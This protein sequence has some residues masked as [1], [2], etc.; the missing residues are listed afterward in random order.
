M[1][2]YYHED[3]DAVAMCSQCG[4]GLCKECAEKRTVILCDDCAK[5]AQLNREAKIF[6]ERR[7]AQWDAIRSVLFSFGALIVG[8]FMAKIICSWLTSNSY[9]H[10]SDVAI[11]S[12]YLLSYIPFAWLTVGQF[13]KRSGC[14]TFLA[15]VLITP[16][17]GSLF[18]LIYIGITAHNIRVTITKP[19]L[20]IILEV[21]F[22][23]L[24]ILLSLALWGYFVMS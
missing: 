10:Y 18:Y 5:K 12:M 6:E 9:I 23:A 7:I 16:W 15:C 22:I 19:S 20:G 14:L 2:C 21:L 24:H 17:F 11:E 3:R 8:Y 4:R 13:I 1:K